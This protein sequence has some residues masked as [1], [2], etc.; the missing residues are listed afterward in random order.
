MFDSNRSIVKKAFL[1]NGLSNALG[2]YE[3]ELVRNDLARRE[4]DEVLG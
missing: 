4:I 3:N 2:G 1:I